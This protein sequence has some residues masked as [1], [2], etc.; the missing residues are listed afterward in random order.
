MSE[1][2]LADKT[3]AELA[4]MAVP[5][6]LALVRE[7]GMKISLAETEINLLARS[8][9]FEASPEDSPALIRSI[10]A[11]RL[12]GHA[13]N[14]EDILLI[15]IIMRIYGALLW[16]KGQ[17]IEEHEREM[18]EAGQQLRN[19]KA[20][21]RRAAEAS[22]KSARRKKIR[23]AMLARRKIQDNNL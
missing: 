3:G 5:G 14:E 12:P 19:E 20:A 10:A 7:A 21:R 9:I 6:A 23:A 13:L 1:K 22:K 17:E 16:K 8:A 15:K 2:Y 11:L 18:L 4:L